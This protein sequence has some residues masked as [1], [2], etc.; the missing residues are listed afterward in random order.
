MDDNVLMCGVGGGDM[1]S[2]SFYKLTKCVP[3]A[4][5]TLGPFSE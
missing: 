3:A 2:V 1:W 5:L 4:L